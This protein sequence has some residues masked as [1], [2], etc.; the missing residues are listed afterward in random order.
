MS[1]HKYLF[2]IIIMMNS[3]DVKNINYL[4]KTIYQ[5]NISIQALVVTDN[6]FEY[7]QLL[8]EI[9]SQY[10]SKISIVESES[11]SYTDV[12]KAVKD[13]I[14]GKYISF[15]TDKMYYSDGTFSYLKTQI[16][17]N[18]LVVDS[19]I[20]VR[21]FSVTPIYVNSVGEEFAYPIS[22]KKEELCNPLLNTNQMI[23][24]F[25]ACFFHENVFEKISF[26]SSIKTEQDKDFLFKYF[27]NFEYYYCFSNKNLYYLDSAENE[28]ATCMIQYEKAWYLDD[29]KN[30]LLKW[31]Q[32]SENFD[33]IR[34]NFIKV[35]TTYLLY[36]RYN[37]NSND[38]NKKVLNEEELE[39]FISLSKE[40]LKY[41]P[42]GVILAKRAR[43]TLNRPLKFLFIKYKCEALG[44]DYE[45]LQTKN[46]FMISEPKGKNTFPKSYTICK[47][48]N[49]KVAITAMNY[50]DGHIVIDFRVYMVDFLNWDDINIEVHYNDKN[51]KLRQVDC[52][53]LLRSFGQTI[54]HRKQYQVRIPV[55]TDAIQV[56]FFL[57][58]DEDLYRLKIDY[59]E[60]A[61]RLNYKYRFNYWRFNSEYVLFTDRS[62]SFFTI[63]RMTDKEEFFRRTTL[64]CQIYKRC[65]SD[66]NPVELEMY[67]LRQEYYKLKKQYKNK[68]IWIM[69]DKLYKAGDNGEYMYH[70]LKEHAPDIEPYYI[71][72]EDSVDYKRLIDA[73]EKNILKT[74]SH[75]ARLMTLL[76][77]CIL[78][79]H[80]NIWVYCGFTK[81]QQACI[82]DL[83]TAKIVCIQHGLTVQKLPSI[84]IDYLIIHCFIVVQ[85]KWK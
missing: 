74:N 56:E 65:I 83:L 52:Y 39:K 21:C 68:R 72:N 35:F 22:N 31:T 3:D 80:T 54:I 28:F 85:V 34:K 78:A 12:Y 63:K 10:K 8:K 2:S 67:K 46:N 24:Y 55:N 45:I 60:A 59:L 50:I 53:G 19:D 4:L 30:F 20:K 25:N 18:A 79:T 17:K 58:I 9:D 76:A 13:V 81:E 84:K 70:Y 73:G 38:R 11:L 66:K 26:D 33:Y 16:E 61:A 77:E 1:K 36:A 62:K 37:C 27:M 71:V 43:Y 40:I 51:A 57:R 44:Y 64:L 41:I 15:V 69:F 5:E 48:E 32:E 82:R 23:L 49:E 75:E 7:Q 29:A 6:S 42:E 47:I 14:S